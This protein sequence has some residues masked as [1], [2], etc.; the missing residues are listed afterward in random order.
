DIELALDDARHYLT[1]EIGVGREVLLAFDLAAEHVRVELRQRV[2][3]GLT[4]DIHLVQRLNRSQP[5]GAALVGSTDGRG[6][7][8]IGTR[9]GYSAGRKSRTLSSYAARGSTSVVVF[10]QRRGFAVLEFG[11]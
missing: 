4:A 5:R 10:A 1:E 6:E 3:E 9:H 11:E 8:G 7:L 2:L